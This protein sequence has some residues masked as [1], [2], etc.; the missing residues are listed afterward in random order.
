MFENILESIILLVAGFVIGILI[1]FLYWGQ[2][3][4]RRARIEDL[5][6][7]LEEKDAEMNEFRT[8]AQQL[9]NERGKQLETLNIQMKNYEKVLKEREKE[10]D[11][12]NALLGQG[13]NNI[14]ELTQKI[15]EKDRSIDSINK[16][17]VDLDKKNRDS[18]YRAERA[19]AKVGE[20]EMVLEGKD[21][22]VTSLKTRMRVMQDDLTYIMGIGPKV[23]S[24][25]KSAGI[26]TFEKLGSTEV[27]R[28]REILVKENPNLLRLVNPE[29]WPEQARVILEGGLETLS[30]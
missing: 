17:I 13:D 6:I 24:V 26:N 22:E 18:V 21:K 14:L 7:S 19:E 2:V 11:K 8:R 9:M 30:V 16:E 3:S 15:G 10:I 12:L 5:E 27:S 20:L 4:E 29:T 1:S 28:I 23:S 25:L